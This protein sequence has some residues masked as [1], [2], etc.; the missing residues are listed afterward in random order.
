MFVAVDLAVPVEVIALSV[1]GMS[2]MFTM[3]MRAM[4]TVTMILAT[5]FQLESQVNINP[6]GHRNIRNNTIT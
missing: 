1:M 2:D 3:P 5:F 6:T 4:M